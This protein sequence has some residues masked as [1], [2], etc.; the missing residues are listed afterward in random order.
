MADGISNYNL[1]VSYCRILDKE[2]SFLTSKVLVKKRK[3]K[4]NFKKIGRRRRQEEGRPN[5][6]DESW[7]PASL[8]N[9]FLAEQKEN[10]MGPRIKFR[11]FSYLNYSKNG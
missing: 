4:V 8:H 3:L 2:D 9:F 10:K 6:I 1:D 7:P 11:Y 5:M